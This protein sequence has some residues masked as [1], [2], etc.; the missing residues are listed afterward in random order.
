MLGDGMSSYVTGT[1]KVKDRVVIILDLE[2]LMM[3]FL[4]AKERDSA[5]EY[6]VELLERRKQVRL[7]YAEDSGVIRKMMLK[8]L[9]SGGYS[10]V[11]SFEHGKAAYD[12]ILELRQLVSVGGGT[13][14]DHVDCII[15]D[16]EMPQMD[17]LTLCKSIKEQSD[18]AAIPAVIVYSSL[19]NEGMAKKCSSVGADAQVSKPHG[20]EILSVLDQLCLNG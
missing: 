16:I 10:N 8:T 12:Y 9:S 1:I 13:I 4:P 2:H 7:I 20:D 5:A 14:T 6:P 3:E 18:G 19:I 15:T 17:G 11:K